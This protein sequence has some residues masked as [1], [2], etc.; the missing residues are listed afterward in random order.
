MHSSLEPIDGRYGYSV[1]VIANQIAYFG[2]YTQS[3]K[4]CKDI[5]VYDYDLKKWG[6][7][8]PIGG[9]LKK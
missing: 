6:K 8:N 3:N 5:F 7:N 2:G 1:S 9:K 4:Y